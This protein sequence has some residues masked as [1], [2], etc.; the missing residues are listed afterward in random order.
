MTIAKS[1]YEHPWRDFLNM[2]TPLYSSTP[3]FIENEDSTLKN[4][5]EITDF[6]MISMRQ[7]GRKLGITFNEIS[8]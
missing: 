7:G 6:K 5:S 8:K 1:H 3:L 4:P 2:E